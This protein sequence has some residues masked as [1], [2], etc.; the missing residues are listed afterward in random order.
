M[1]PQRT[2]L[3][4]CKK[5]EATLLAQKRFYKETKCFLKTPNSKVKTK[6]EKDH[7]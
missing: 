7:K 3:H 2:S 5:R 6:L 1:K 4:N